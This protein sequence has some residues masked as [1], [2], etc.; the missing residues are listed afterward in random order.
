MVVALQGFVPVDGQQRKKNYSCLAQVAVAMGL[1]PNKGLAADVTA[2]A[3]E[4]KTKAVL[5]I[6]T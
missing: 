6:C 4:E 3:C 5:G 2:K 1:E